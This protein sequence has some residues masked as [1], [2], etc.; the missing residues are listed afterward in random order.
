MQQSAVMPQRVVCRSGELG[1]IA[2]FLTSAR[3]RPSG[4]TIEGAAGIG[5]TTLWSSAAEQARE[6]GSRILSACVGRAES[7][8]T[9]AAV[10]DLLSDVESSVFIRLP[11]AQRVAVD[12]V[13]LN[14]DD[15]GCQPDQRTVAAAFLAIVETLAADAPVLLAI[16]DLQWLDA[17]S[18]AVLTFAARRLKGRVGVL[19]TERPQPGCRT[20]MSWLRVGAKNDIGHV[21]LRPA[22]HRRAAHAR[23]GSVGQIAT[24]PD[25]AAH[26]RDFA[27]QPVLCAGARTRRRH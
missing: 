8:M 7:A 15:E 25:D 27:G 5:K 10:A 13:L 12:T 1:A 24:P 9:Y 21:L 3:A 11:N 23:F 6:H 4:L 16:D 2:D 14:G 18:R 22:E 20:A 17:S 26:R 19:V